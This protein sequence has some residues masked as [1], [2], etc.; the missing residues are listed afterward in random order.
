MKYLLIL[1]TT[2]LFSQSSIVVSGTKDYTIGEIVPIMQ[3]DMKPKAISLG[4]PEYTKPV[5]LNPIIKKKTL[6]QKILEFLKRL[7]N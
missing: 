3:Q 2:I 1:F 5:E 6:V 4:V 7:I